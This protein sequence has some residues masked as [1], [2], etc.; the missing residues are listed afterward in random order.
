MG[1][2]QHRPGL[3]RLTLTQNPLTAAPAPEEESSASGL[4]Q[5]LF[6]GSLFG[7]WY[8]FNIWFNIYNK[9]VLKTFP[10]PLTITAF[11]F[12]VGGLVACATWVLGLHKKP[13]ATVETVCVCVWGL[14]G[15]GGETLRLCGLG[16]PRMSWCRGS[17]E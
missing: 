3:H 8:L 10:H 15:R 16:M 11:Q 4:A 12:L 9:Q 1:F 6:L 17:G 5:T 2:A 7:L 14:G 13:E